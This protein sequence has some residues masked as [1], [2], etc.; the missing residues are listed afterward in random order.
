MRAEQCDNSTTIDGKHAADTKRFFRMLI[1]IG[2][3]RTSYNP[4]KH[5]TAM[6]T[7]SDTCGGVSEIGDG[8]GDVALPPQVR[9]LWYREREVATLIYTR[10][11]STAADVM[12]NLSSPLSNSSVRTMLRR[13][14]EKG[15]L[16][17]CLGRPGRGAPTVYLPMAIPSAAKASA[18]Q[19]LSAQYF[20]GSMVNVAL[21]AL[22]AASERQELV[23]DSI[24]ESIEKARVVRR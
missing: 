16:T 22:S 9:K 1:A 12:T 4:M 3:K 15:V 18:L 13:L 17:Q 7:R 5:S 21:A 19:Q 23:D 20:D 14:V 2:T 8:G 6:A 24:V 11:P 10:G